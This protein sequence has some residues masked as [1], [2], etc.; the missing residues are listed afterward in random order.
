MG[1]LVRSNS[2]GHMQGIHPDGGS[3]QTLPVRLGSSTS[4]ASS[5]ASLR[6]QAP[7]GTQQRC[8]RAAARNPGRRG[9]DAQ[10]RPGELPRG[11]PRPPRRPAWRPLRPLRL[12]QAGG[13]SR[14]RGPG[15]PRRAA[16]LAR[17]G[18]RRP[19]RRTS[20]ARAD[21]P[22]AAHRARAL[23]PAGPVPA[24]DRREPAGPAG[25]ALPDLRRAG[26][27]LPPVGRPGGS[28]RALRLRPRHPRAHAPGGPHLH[29]PP[30]RRAP[31][32]RG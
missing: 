8:W 11:Q 16:R 3:G 31:P 27:L 26:G 12:R 15:R 30:A 5:P 24:A 20:P 13:R 25:I 1:E 23:D 28:P 32:G 9:R 18:P 7:E 29:R 6:T 4:M 19:L 21:A 10:G 14:G 17:G 2:T 22:A